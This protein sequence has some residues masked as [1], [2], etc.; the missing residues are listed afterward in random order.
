MVSQHISMNILELARS[1]I[2]KDLL[3]VLAPTHENDPEFH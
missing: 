1:I 2:G 3:C